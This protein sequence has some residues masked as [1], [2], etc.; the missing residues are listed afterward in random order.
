MRR[1]EREG[2]ARTGEEREGRTRK[3]GKEH[4]WKEGRTG[5]ERPGRTREGRGRTECGRLRPIST[6][7]NFDFGQFLDV[8]FLDQER[9]KKQKQK[10]KPKIGKENSLGGTINVGVCVKASPARRPAFTDGLCPPF[11]FQQAFMFHMKVC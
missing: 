11:R 5:G 4:G 6:S 7:A 8:E 2:G 1:K 3:E 9:E 10:K